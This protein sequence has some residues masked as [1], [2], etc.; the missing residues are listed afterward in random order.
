MI[1]RTD[2]FHILREIRAYVW[3][4]ALNN[5]SI[6]NPEARERARPRNT[7]PDVAELQLATSREG[8]DQNERNP[9][10]TDH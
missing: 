9:P 2:Q 6:N 8:T 7:K 1:Y 4:I 10:A 3:C 5:V